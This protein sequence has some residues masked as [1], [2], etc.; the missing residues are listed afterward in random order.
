MAALEQIRE[1]MTD[2][3]TGQG[4]NAVTAWPAK[5]RGTL[6]ETVAAVSVRKCV[7]A[8][9]GFQDYLGQRYNGETGSWEELYGK[10]LS[11]TLGLD[12]YA[13]GGMGAA[14]CQQVFDRLAQALQSE[15]P[16]GLRIESLS[17]GEVAYQQSTGLLHC[18]AE[19]ACTAYV[20]AVADEGG[21]FVDFEV[22]G[23]RK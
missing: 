16:A 7:A 8:R 11:L 3:L 15:G 21:E 4:V 18:P 1:A 13:P 23:M 12:L 6:T 19:V 22:K 2:F 14:G 20:Y 17:R 5:E 10:E 9:A